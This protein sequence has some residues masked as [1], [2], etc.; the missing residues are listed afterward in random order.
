[1]SWRLPAFW[2]F[3]MAGLGLVYP[4]QAVWFQQSAGLTGAQL[5]VV[6]A[7]RPIMG[8]IGQ[9]LWGRVAD[10]TGARARVLSV[11]LGG[12]ALAYLALPWMESAI[13]IAAV[14]TLAS[15]FGTSVMPLGTSVS[16]AALGDLASLRF[17][18]IR[19]W[20]T[21]GYLVL[22]FPFRGSSRVGASAPT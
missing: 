15:F 16:M 13:A 14:F 11:V 7:L 22:W 12:A 17:G 18:R 3:Y 9:P 5:G 1:M 4:F 20:G 21:V 2:F 6:L 10:R 8:I 19:V